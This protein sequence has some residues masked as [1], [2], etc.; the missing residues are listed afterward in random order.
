[1]IQLLL[2]CNFQAILLVDNRANLFRIN[3]P[4]FQVFCD[5]PQTRRQHKKK[6]LNRSALPAKKSTVFPEILKLK[7][8]ERT[9]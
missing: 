2:N 7:R 5:L 8:P 9:P 1:M 4:F 6:N 3:F